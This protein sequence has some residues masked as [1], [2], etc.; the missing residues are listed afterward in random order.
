MFEK[1]RIEVEEVREKPGDDLDMK[2]TKRL[3]GEML[4]RNP[5]SRPSAQE[6]VHRFTRLCSSY[7]DVW[8]SLNLDGKLRHL[9]FHYILLGFI[10]VRDQGRF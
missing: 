7:T 3:I 2:R 1:G 4:D 9:C 5:K 10:H 8:K 6:L